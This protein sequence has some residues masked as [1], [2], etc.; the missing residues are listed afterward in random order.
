V[1]YWPAVEAELKKILPEHWDTR[2]GNFELRILTFSS[3]IW[4]EEDARCCPTGGS[5]KVELGIKD[6]GFIVKSS[7]VEKSN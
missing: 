5:V 6:S 1:K 4:K 2:G 3:P 7:R